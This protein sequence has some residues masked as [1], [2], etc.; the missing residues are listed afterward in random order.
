MRAIFPAYY[1]RDEVWSPESLARWK[2]VIASRGY[3]GLVAASPRPC[4][5]ASMINDFDRSELVVA[6]LIQAAIVCHIP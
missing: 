1:R 5:A 2:D 6:R 4:Y 3:R